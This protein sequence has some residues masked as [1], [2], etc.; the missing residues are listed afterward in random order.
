L[1]AFAAIPI[2]L[3]VSIQEADTGSAT[4]R[5]QF[6]DESPESA[7][8]TRPQWQRRFTLHDVARLAGVAPITG[9]RALNSPEQV[10]AEVRKKVANAIAR[11]GY[12]R[13]RLAGTI[14]HIQRK[15]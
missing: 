11:I 6:N 14:G 12:V 10:S 3:S 7:G 5:L 15:D 13:N 4:V 2:H 9:S 1:A 8:T